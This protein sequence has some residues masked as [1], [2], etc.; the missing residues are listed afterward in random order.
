MATRKTPARRAPEASKRK[1]RQRAAAPVA[2]SLDLQAA[3]RAAVREVIAP[4]AQMKQAAD[5]GR[6]AD[7]LDTPTTGRP[8]TAMDNAIGQT[9]LALDE[10]TIAVQH[11]TERLERSVLAPGVNLA[12][13]SKSEAIP[14]MGASPVLH[15][16]TGLHAR[17]SHLI[18]CV[19]D[20]GNRLEA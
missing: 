7:L 9:S 20:I 13:P 18:A 11:L 8:T 6:A 2:T 4:D 10:L 17:I 12:A 16:I 3:V 15:Q 1:P 19:H 14:S 5:I